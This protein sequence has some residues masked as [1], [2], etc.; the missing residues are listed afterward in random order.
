MINMTKLRELR[1]GS[2]VTQQDL[3]ELLETSQP[4][5]SK[6][7]NDDEAYKRIPLYKAIELC[8]L[9]GVELNDLV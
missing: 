8:D 3:A 2:D 1:R 4:F 9:F 6:L 7:E 5:I